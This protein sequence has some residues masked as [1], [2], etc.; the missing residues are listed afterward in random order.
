M[1][2][3][4]TDRTAMQALQKQSGELSKKH[5]EAADRK[6][7]Q[8]MDELMKQQME[9]FPKMNNLMIGQFK[10]MFVILAFFAGFIWVV[11]HFDPTMQD[12]IT[13]AMQDDGQGCDK[14]ANDGLFTTCFSPTK[15]GTWVAHAKLYNG[16]NVVGENSTAFIYGAINQDDVYLP[17][18]GEALSVYTDKKEYLPND[19]VMIFANATNARKITVQLD[20]TTRFF[21][22]LPF[23]IPILNVHRIYEPYWWFIFVTVITGLLISI[24]FNIYEKTKKG[25]GT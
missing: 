19:Q 7:Q 8:Q 22:D 15:A 14:N 23:T 6:D 21:V 17:K 9:L 20:S 5:K 16:E 1:Q 11:N 25:V 18:K 13:L 10:V 4:F 3:K 24:G 12:D 2:N